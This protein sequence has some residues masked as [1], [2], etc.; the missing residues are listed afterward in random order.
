MKTFIVDWGKNCM[1]ARYALVQGDSEEDALWTADVIGSP[2]KIAEFILGGRGVDSAYMEIE[3]PEDIFA[4]QKID[5]FKWSESGE[6]I[7]KIYV[8][9]K[10][11]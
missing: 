4:G 5:K 3:Q 2:F 1:G 11:K 9:P 7:S 8:N 10:L 6:M